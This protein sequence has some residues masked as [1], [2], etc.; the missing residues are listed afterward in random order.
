MYQLYAIVQF[1]Y[2]DTKQVHV[3]ALSLYYWT[4]KVARLNKAHFQPACCTRSRPF[5]EKEAVEVINGKIK[6]SK[7]FWQ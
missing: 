3:V 5:V 6:F 1:L 7:Q 4:K 2:F